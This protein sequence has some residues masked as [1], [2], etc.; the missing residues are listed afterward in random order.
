METPDIVRYGDGYYRHTIYGIGPYIA[1]YPEQ[2]LLACIVQGWCPRWAMILFSYQCLLY[3][4]Y[5]IDAMLNGIIW[6][7]TL[8]DGVHTNWRVLL[9]KLWIRTH[10]GMTT[11]SLA[12]SWYVLA[13]NQTSACPHCVFLSR[14]PMAFLVQTFTSCYHQTFSTKSLKAHSKITWWPG[15]QLISISS[16]IQLRPNGFSLT[17]TA[18]KSSHKWFF[19]NNHDSSKMLAL[20]PHPHSLAFVA[21]QKVVDLNSG[22]EMTQRR[23]W[24]YVILYQLF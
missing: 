13:I 16:T 15:L 8:Q 20:L 9:S 1:D 4:I 22:R 23:W 18:G 6:M 5:S 14:L 2:V 7:T 24:K 10:Y 12:T 21:S 11:A 3:V 19:F 17:L